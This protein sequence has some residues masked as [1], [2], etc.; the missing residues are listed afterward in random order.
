MIDNVWSYR[1]VVVEQVRRELVVRSADQRMQLTASLP[2]WETLVSTIQL[3]V[4]LGSQ[5]VPFS[6]Q[7][8]IEE[9]SF[10]SPLVSLLSIFQKKKTRSSLEEFERVYGKETGVAAHPLA[11]HLAE[12]VFACAKE[13]ELVVDVFLKATG[14]DVEPTFLTVRLKDTPLEKLQALFAQLNAALT[15]LERAQKGES[16]SIPSLTS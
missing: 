7:A 1:G 6:Q 9:A 13:L 2:V 11:E 3:Q 8:V 10:M 4:S 16:P 5:R 14:A 15:R 12:F